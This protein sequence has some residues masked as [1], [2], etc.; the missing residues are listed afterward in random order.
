MKIHTLKKT[1]GSV[2]L[3]SALMVAPSAFAGTMATTTGQAMIGHNGNVV[4]RNAEVTS[5]SGN[6]VNAIARF[7]NIVTSWV[8]TTNASTTIG[9]NNTTSAST[10]DIHVGDRINVAGTLSALGSVVSVN[11]SKIMDKTSM[12]SFKSK[13]G[14]IQSVN[15]GNG[16]FVLKTGAKT[17]TVQTNATTAFTVKTTATSTATATTLSALPI[18]GTVEV[19]GTVNGDG[20]VL[21]ATKVLVKPTIMKTDKKSW[22]DLK[23]E[24]KDTR[25][26]DKENGN[27]KG[28]FHISLGNH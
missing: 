8:F 19:Q 1:L 15:T 16:T 18:N 20:T 21:T 9:A 5:V 22:E 24:W 28:L 7:A 25:K 14:T 6:V 11:A 23:K 4:V 12:T 27:R 13:V 17:L 26:E 2:A 3:L 10:T